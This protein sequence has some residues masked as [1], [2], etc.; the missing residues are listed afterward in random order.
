MMMETTEHRTIRRPIR[1]FI[2]APP[3]FFKPKRFRFC[4]QAIIPEE[5][6]G[7]IDEKE[8]EKVD[9]CIGGL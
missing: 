1:D 7:I 5:T 2:D 6:S 9:L 8:R 3:L 4:C